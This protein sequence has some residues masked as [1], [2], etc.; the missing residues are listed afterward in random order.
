MTTSDQFERLLEDGRPAFAEAWHAEAYALVQVL[1]ETGRVE[2]AQWAEAFGSALR[3]AAANGAPD[4]GPTYYAALADAIEQVLLDD[5]RLR[6][7][8]AEQRVEAWRAAYH[9]TP[10][11]KP[12]TLLGR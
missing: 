9:K 12:V 7:G 1:I 4:D 6:A 11:G 8:E 5:G 3:K 10:H 2:P